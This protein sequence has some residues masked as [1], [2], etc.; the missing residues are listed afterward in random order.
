[1]QGSAHK[2][3]SHCIKSH[4]IRRGRPSSL[5]PGRCPLLSQAMQRAHPEGGRLVGGHRSSLKV[6]REP[7]KLCP[8]VPMDEVEDEDGR[9]N[10]PPPV[11]S[12]QSQAHPK[13]LVPQRT[14]TLGAWSFFP[15]GR[16]WSYGFHLGFNA[17]CCP[18]SLWPPVSDWMQGRSHMQVGI[19]LQEKVS[20]YKDPCSVTLDRDQ[21]RPVGSYSYCSLD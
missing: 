13:E 3:G 9:D 6:R 15:M 21:Q 2:K 5:C 20:L 16:G 11:Y 12:S 7:G 8:L 18:G 10:P 1:M 17:R 14:Q 4:C 19:S